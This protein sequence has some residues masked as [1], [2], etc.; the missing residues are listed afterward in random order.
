MKKQL[1]AGLSIALMLL[2]AGCGGDP[3]PQNTPPADEDETPIVEEPPVA[4]PVPTSDTPEDD[5][6]A[7]DDRDIEL[8][9]NAPEHITLNS[10]SDTV[11]VPLY[12][13]LTV[14]QKDLDFKCGTVNFPSQLYV[15]ETMELHAGGESDSNDDDLMVSEYFQDDQKRYVY[16]EADG[17]LPATRPATKHILSAGTIYDSEPYTLEILTEMYEGCTITEI[18][19]DGVDGFV[20][21]PDTEG[22]DTVVAEVLLFINV[23]SYDYG[24]G[25]AYFCMDIGYRG[26][27]ADRSEVDFDEITAA[28]LELTT[29]EFQPAQ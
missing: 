8:D 23:G 25:T 4:D 3:Q 10:I 27:L 20:V 15:E 22:N 17:T 18:T 21:R 12:C 7:D 14:D 11:S 5:D 1:L 29:V 6:T 16:A 24:Y 28:L 26:G 19:A 9:E 2:A 13:T